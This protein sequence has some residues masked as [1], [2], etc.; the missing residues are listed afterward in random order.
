MRLCDSAENFFF[1]GFEQLKGG[2]AHLMILLRPPT[3][4]VVDCGLRRH[5]GLRAASSPDL[6][7]LLY[8]SLEPRNQKKSLESWVR[9]LRKLGVGLVPAHERFTSSLDRD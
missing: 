9:R 1:T 6:P 8:A 7:G 5:C 3:P 4:C 2:L